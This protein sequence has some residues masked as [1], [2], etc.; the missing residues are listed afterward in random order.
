M[1]D[2]TL[3]YNARLVDKNIDVKNGAVLIS[4]NKIAG[5]PSKETVKEMLKDQNVSKFDAKG[6]AL[7]P[8]FIDMHAHFRDPGLTYK[9]DIESGT[10]A[11]AAGGYTL[12]VLM[13][14]TK[15][16]VSSQE[17]AQINN[18]KAKLAGYCNVIQSVSI[19]KDFDGK[20]I[21]HLD[22]LNAKVVPLITEDGKEVASSAVMLEAMK[23][24]AAKKII[25]SCHCEDPSLAL[26]AK[27]YRQNALE[28]L[29]SGKASP[30]QK[31][32]AAANLKEANVLLKLA[33]DT[34]TLRNIELAKEAGCHLHLCHVSTK[35]CLDAVRRAKA[36]GLNITC[37]VTPH[38]LGL[39]GE[40]IPEI[41]NVVNPP[42]RSEEDRLACV[43][44]LKDG[45]ADVI[46]TDHAPHS[47]EDKKGGSPGFSGLETSFAVSY[48]NLV[49]KGGMK[50]KQ[51]SELMS[52][53]PAEILG[54]KNRG[55]LEEEYIADLVLVNLDEEWTVH[56]DEFISKGKFT[57]LENKK[58]SGSI[59][60]TFLDGKIVFQA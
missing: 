11:A 5:F 59:M 6:A 54:L 1:K 52:A 18:S 2:L 40:K 50:L 20:T 31:K 30:A 37:E 46:A 45:T 32:E 42:L 15:P 43:Q 53:R 26:A 28:L 8:G 48:T 23:K 24:A 10:M 47:E 25:V 41:F 33:E 44:A 39:S 9:E 51:L 7:M 35:T 38:H 4:K 12:C 58:L 3:I 49:K 19:T 56:G 14:N 17:M 57:P 55:L 13:P 36:E 21:S 16:V 29:K 60:A 22:E 27:P 34:A